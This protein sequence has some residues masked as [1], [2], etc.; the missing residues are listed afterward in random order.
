MTQTNALLEHF[1]SFAQNNL[2][3]IHESP[4]LH[5]LKASFQDAAQW[6]T[7]AADLYII[8]LHQN[9]PAPGLKFLHTFLK[10]T[11]NALIAL[12][13]PQTLDLFAHSPITNT[14]IQ[15][16][17]ID[18][19]SNNFWKL[20]ACSTFLELLLR[21]EIHFGKKRLESKFVSDFKKAQRKLSQAW[22]NLPPNTTPQTRQ[23]LALDTLLRL[24]F[25]AFLAQQHRLD[26]RPNFILE[27]AART[28]AEQRSIY[29][30]FIR[31]FFFGTLNLPPR[32]RA[33][34]AKAFGKIPFLNG[35]LFQPTHLEAQN[36]Q[37]DVPN[38]ILHDILIRCFQHYTFS[39]K[40]CTSS[41]RLDPMML[42][43]VFE[44]LMDREKRAKTGS[45]YTP[46]NLV[47]NIVSRAFKH[48]LAQ[49]TDVCPKTIQR[50]LEHPNTTHMTPHDAEMLDNAL[51]H[52]KI[53]D[54]AAGSGA[55]LQGAFHLLHATRRALIT[56]MGKEEH[57]GIL[58]RHILLHN[59]YGIDILEQANRICELRLWLAT[60]RFYREDE[61]LPPLPN[62]DL[63][64]RCGHTLI[65][66]SQYAC[67][68]GINTPKH[69]PKA[70]NLVQRYG[71]ANAVAKRRLAAQIDRLT[72]QREQQLTQN[73]MQK[74]HHDIQDLQ[75]LAAQKDLFGKTASLPFALRKK[76]STLQQHLRQLQ[77]G[78]QANAPTSFAFDI[79]Y[80]EIMAQGGFD[81]IL[82]N[83]PWFS[84]HNCST[85]EQNILKV[86]YKTASAPKTKDFK[87][88]ATDISALFVEKSIQCLKPGGI[89]AMLL[90]NKLFAAPSYGSFRKFI[91]AQ[92]SI[93]E[94]RDWADSKEN[95]FAAATYPADLILQ[96]IDAAQRSQN[97]CLLPHETC[98]LDLSA[99]TPEEKSFLAIP[100]TLSSHFTIKRG[101]C[102]GA[103]DL[104][105]LKPSSDQAQHLAPCHRDPRL[106]PHALPYLMT[107]LRGANI[108]PYAF[109]PKEAILFTHDHENLSKMR[110]LHPH[111]LAWLETHKQRL[112]QRA[113]LGT[114]PYYALF[115]V[116]PYLF[117]PKV[118]WRDIACDLTACFIPDPSVMPLNTVYY[119]PVQSEDEGYLLSAY[120][121]AKPIREFCRLRAEH[122]Q[123]DYRR[124][125]AWLIGQIPWPFHRHSAQG[126]VEQIIQLSRA[127]HDRPSPSRLQ[128]NQ[129]RLD[130]LIQRCLYANAITH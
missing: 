102:T 84:L 112:A 128:K 80:A 2:T 47:K 65:D 101:I 99:P 87:A 66:L 61:L 63:N 104:F 43:H 94:S 19:M 42:G 108:A 15:A 17:D 4:S 35:G 33:S 23:I 62:L 27:E 59:L 95:T 107:A 46:M 16:H 70:A 12:L 75:N 83:P 37:L 89:M 11:S 9:S 51:Q 26:L 113:G 77:E 86:L 60:T 129:A 97:A 41:D 50:F 57:P 40:E 90:P 74:C 79:H 21:I 7:H 53:L 72:R 109:S 28:R 100:N 36:P 117:K 93:L 130:T 127:C 103:N 56:H 92:A 64:I 78:Q 76:L 110:P 105:V 54:P 98:R 39:T 18:W 67:V 96:R 85:Q 5:A 24:L 25:L 120:L 6:K 126:D 14:L 48:W 114:K 55:F 68:L 29:Q 58:A 123:N 116:S 71:L 45:F 13:K 88:Q 1:R 69:D 119:I 122:A 44:S 52:I 91:A 118:V 81:I 73:L 20:T 8:P 22:Q 32:R 30:H 34:R 121:N 125:F 38:D 10:N 111:V 3:P 31:P 115:G 49:K 82:G 124:Y 106:A